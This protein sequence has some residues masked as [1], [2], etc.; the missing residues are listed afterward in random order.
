MWSLCTVDH[1]HR[2]STAPAQSYEPRTIGAP[3]TLS[4]SLSLVFL[5]EAG[6]RRVTCF[7]QSDLSLSNRL[8][9]GSRCQSPYPCRYCGHGRLEQ[10]G[11]GTC[12]LSRGGTAAIADHIEV[13]WLRKA[14]TGRPRSD[15]RCLSSF[16]S[17][18]IRDAANAA[19]Q[20]Q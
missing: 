6:L 16:S 4:L 9:D 7:S 1:R 19:D 10:A 15:R 3:L 8:G 12:C 18:L 13:S 17:F 11:T 5:F 14:G 2:L 20:R